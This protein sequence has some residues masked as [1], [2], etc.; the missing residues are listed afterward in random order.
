M[1]SQVE[2]LM[3]GYD[4]VLLVIRFAVISLRVIGHWLLLQLT[5]DQ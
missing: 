5:N 4:T 2:H 3:F 1:C